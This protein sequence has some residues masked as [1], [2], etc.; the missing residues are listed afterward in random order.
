MISMTSTHRQN[1]CLTRMHLSIVPPWQKPSP[2][3]SQK[4]GRALQ[5][6]KLGQELHAQR[7]AATQVA[8]QSGKRTAKTRGVRIAAIA[9]PYLDVRHL[10]KALIGMSRY[11]TDGSTL[12]AILE[13]QRR[14]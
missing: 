8:S 9:R 2:S 11:D 12:K 10:A 1:R 4:A 3:L 14:R 5:A 13:E 6:L 7:V